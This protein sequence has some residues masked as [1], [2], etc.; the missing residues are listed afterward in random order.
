MPIAFPGMKNA[1]ACE[2]PCQITDFAFIVNLT[3]YTIA[4]VHDENL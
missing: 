3:K 4:L 2:I 1:I